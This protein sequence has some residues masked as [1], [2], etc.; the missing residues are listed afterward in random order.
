MLIG[1]LLGQQADQV[2]DPTVRSIA[3]PV[4]HVV[5]RPIGLA[6]RSRLDR[7]D[8]LVQANGLLEVKQATVEFLDGFANSSKANIRGARFR[9]LGIEHSPNHEGRRQCL[10]KPSAFAAEGTFEVK[11]NVR[12]IRS[13]FECQRGARSIDQ[14]PGDRHVTKE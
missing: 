14:D 4:M 12:A 10:G 1:M 11:H 3:I 6:T 7:R 8:K 2:T 13:Q 9:T 5:A